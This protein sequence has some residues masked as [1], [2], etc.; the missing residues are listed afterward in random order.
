MSDRAAVSAACAWKA[1]GC[2]RR[3]LVRAQLGAAGERGLDLGGLDVEVVGVGVVEGGG[4]VLPEVGERRSDLLLGREHRDGGVGHE[5]QEGPEVADRQELRD[6]RPALRALHGRQ[7]R[8]LARRCV[9][10]GGRGDLDGL[11]IT[12]G[13]LREGREPAQRL[14]LVT[15]EVDPHGPILGCREQVDEAAADGELPAVLHLVDPFVAGG[16]EVGRELVEIHQIT[17]RQAKSVRAQRRIRDL[18]RQGDGADDHHGGV[19]VVRVRVDQG[20]QR[21]DA[22]AD[23]VR[24][25]GEMGFVGDAAGGVEP[26]RPGLEPHP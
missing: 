6:V 22:Q 18:L 7:L 23:E 24:R 19:R 26:H 15:E 10:L 1:T 8:E 16:G 12:Q 3:T 17:D 13:P 20:V 25:R 14:D 9:E 11:G 4:D 5:V 2:S 21:G